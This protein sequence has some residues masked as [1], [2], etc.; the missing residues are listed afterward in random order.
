LVSGQTP[1]YSQNMRITFSISR[2]N[3]LTWSNPIDVATTQFANRGY[4]TM[5]L[6]EATGNLAIG[7]YD[8]R[9][10]PTFQSLE[11]MAAV[12]PA[13]TLDCLVNQ[14]PLSDPLFTIPA[15]TGCIGGFGSGCTGTTGVLGI[16]MQEADKTHML[17]SGKSSLSAPHHGVAGPDMSTM[18]K[19]GK[20]LQRGP[21]S[22]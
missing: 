15:F 12:I 14:I 20:R 2:N 1:D 22:K 5:A 10:D 6:D 17:A 9:N 3:G 8:G 13:S 16:N 21:R 18:G 4:Q 19:L 7:W 11:Y